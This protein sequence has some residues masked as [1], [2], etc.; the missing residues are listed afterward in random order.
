MPVLKSQDDCL[1]RVTKEELEPS[2]LLK[3]LLDDFEHLQL[4]EN[5]TTEKTDDVLSEGEQSIPLDVSKPVL[6]KIVEWL[7]YQQVHGPGENEQKETVKMKFDK[8]EMSEWESNFVDVT[9]AILMELIA[10]ADYLDISKLKDLIGRCP[11][12]PQRENSTANP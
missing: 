4:E 1:F 8:Y 12:S 6:A 9:P 10:A 7:R 3:T 2:V 5:T 11:K